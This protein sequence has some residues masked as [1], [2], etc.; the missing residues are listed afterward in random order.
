MAFRFAARTLL[1]LGKELISSD[2]VALYELIKNA[3]DAKSPRVEIVAE[4]VL[5]HSAYVE[6][7]DELEDDEEPTEVLEKLRRQVFTHAL[8]SRVNAFLQTLEEHEDDAEDFKKALIESYRSFNWLEIRDTGHGMSLKELDTVFL[9][10]GTRSRRAENVAGAHF[11]G[12]K[13][14][15]RLSTM[16]LGDA[17]RVTTTRT[18]DKY[19]NILDVDW[20][21]F[22]HES[23]LEV[24]NIEIEPERGSKKLNPREHGTRIRISALHGDW[25]PIRFRELFQGDIAR[26][27][28]PFE[29][30]RANQLLVVRHNNDRISIPSI[31]EKLLK[32][33][34][35]TCRAA[36][37]FE[38]DEPVL[39]GII[40]Y[41]LRSQKRPIIQRGAEIYSVAQTV[42]KR[43]GK[44][45]HA[46]TEVTPIRARALRDLGPFEVE[47]YWYNRAL[48]EAVDGYTTKKQETRDEI[49]QW[50]GGPMLYRRGYRIL[51]YGNRDDDWLELDRN[52]FGQAGFK[53][54]RQQ[55]IGRVRVNASHTALSEQ[56]NREGL[57]ESEATVALKTLVMWLLHNEL[58]S[59][60]NDADKLERLSRREAEAMTEEFRTTQS[61]VEEMIRQLSNQVPSEQRAKVREL[62]AQVAL[63]AEQ[64]EVLVSETDNLVTE[65]KEDREKFVHLAGIGLITEFIFHELDRAVS[66]TIKTLT[67]ARGSRR[68]ASLASLEEQLK[69]LQKRIS[70]F[71]ELSGE[72][73]QSKTSFDVCD[74]LRTV[75]AGH[76]NQFERHGIRL[77][78]NVPTAGFRIKAVRGMI[79]QII[80]NLVANSVYWLKQQKKITKDFKPEIIVEA[81]PKTMSISVEDN[82]PGVDPSRREII[83]QPFITSKPPGQGRGLGLYISR[84]L[85]QHHGWQLYVEQQGKVRRTGRLNTFVLD[86]GEEK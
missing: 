33:A 48:V 7:L 71:D 38:D 21:L 47:I 32:V 43:R 49:A 29:P 77:Q 30:G 52:A 50:S 84:E 20:S 12:D 62:G 24:G 26:M 6:A 66:H 31:P 41:R 80:E 40:D 59:L 67:D 10:V 73:R 74:L 15:G 65:T 8:G 36:L 70:A 17:L 39:K 61:K 34:H 63:L 81:D 37:T 27:I 25:T 75:L 13:G 42:V 14:V 72:K 82:G 4:V 58:R 1:E 35:A 54:N 85:A 60:I 22:T 16:R 53:L 28:D 11:L 3:V 55:V 69:T 68:E 23:E 5:P 45:G 19:W 86:M 57:V 79:I 51:P 46:A 64:C 56:T 44:K 78:L 2:E 18:D 76:A 83:F 9:T